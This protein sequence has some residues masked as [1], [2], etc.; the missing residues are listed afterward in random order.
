MNIT[1]CTNN[2]R[3]NWISVQ[4]EGLYYGGDEGCLKVERNANKKWK[5][6]DPEKWFLKNP[7]FLALF[8]EKAI[9]QVIFTP[10]GSLVYCLVVNWYKDNWFSRR[11]F[12]RNGCDYDKEIEVYL[13]GEKLEKFWSIKEHVLIA[14]IQQYYPK[15]AELPY[16]K[17]R[18]QSLFPLENSNIG[19]CLSGG[20]FV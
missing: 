6:D 10:K 3:V 2:E 4:Q 8:V 1:F 14:T 11:L 20:V 9:Q 15:L 18:I 19:V 12:W 17:L 13:S 16:D 5:L 7:R